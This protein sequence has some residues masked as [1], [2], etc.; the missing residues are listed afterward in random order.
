VPEAA[1]T[2]RRATPQDIE[3]WLVLRLA[4]WPDHAP[5]ELRAEMPAMLDDPGGV[6]LLAIS[7]PGVV[8]GMAEATIRTDYVNGCDTSPVGFLE[9]IYVVPAARRNGVARKLV[10]AVAGWA[11]G[12]GLTELA[13]DA[14][15]D[16][17]ASHQMHDALGFSETE[18][19]V[20]FRK[21][22]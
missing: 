1:P 19:V 18:R 13:S 21:R 5:D 10:E 8:L 11:R 15:L 4:L 16:N 17:I 3:A 14:P 20:F 22:V 2:V 9:G 7:G 12:E 6:V